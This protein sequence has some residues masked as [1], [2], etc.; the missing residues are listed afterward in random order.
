MKRGIL[1]VSIILLIS[2]VVAIFSFSGVVAY[3]K[4]DTNY[5]IYTAKAYAD[6]IGGHIEIYVKPEA[7]SEIIT[8]YLDGTRLAVMESEVDGYHAVIMEDGLG[9]VKNENLT[10]T[11]SYNER[12]A[13]VIGLIAVITVALILLITYY[14]RNS[15][16]FKNKHR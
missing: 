14:R 4:E 1:L 2:I 16:Y 6:K 10:T 11:L 13:I 7:T 9:Y 5:L 15:E 12:V 8:T 3:A